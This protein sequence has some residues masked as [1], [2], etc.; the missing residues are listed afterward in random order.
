MLIESTTDLI[1]D[2]TVR[3]MPSGIWVQEAALVNGN[4]LV[5]ASDT[6]ALYRRPNSCTDILGNG[7]IRSIAIPESSHLRVADDQQ[8]HFIVEHRAGYVGLQGG[9]VLL[10][11][12]NDVQ[13]FADKLSALQNKNEI[14]RLSLAPN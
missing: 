7:F 6:L 3:K 13:M 2:L 12:L 1:T 4:A 8:G 5:V 14:V 10:I 11:T 9:K